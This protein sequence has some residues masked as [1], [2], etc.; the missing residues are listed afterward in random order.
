LCV[1]TPTIKGVLTH[2]GSERSLDVHMLSL[3]LERSGWE[4]GEGARG[5]G[6]QAGVAG[7]IRERRWRDR[8]EKKEISVQPMTGLCRLLRAQGGETTF[9]RSGGPDVTGARPGQTLTTR[10]T[11]AFRV[12][13]SEMW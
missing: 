4:L 3:G 6:R 1:K 9:A 13:R 11:P 7:G 8:S 5:C 2:N 12:N 10:P